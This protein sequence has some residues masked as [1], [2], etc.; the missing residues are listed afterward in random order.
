MPALTFPDQQKVKFHLSYS[1]AMP[2]GDV[3]LLQERMGNIASTELVTAIVGLIARCDRVFGE[4]E[5]NNQTAGIAYNRIITGDTN[6][7]DRADRPESLRTRQKAYL[8][9]T[10][11]LALRLGV[12]N[13]TNPANSGYLHF[14][15]VK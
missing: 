8:R 12:L 11:L 7:A 5:P 9:E 6:R 10:D 4:S 1:G 3:A 15:V 2:I 13:Y 14:G